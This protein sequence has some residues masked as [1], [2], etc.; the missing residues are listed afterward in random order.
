M[1]EE[2]TVY[3]EESVRNN[4]K[5]TNKLI[6]LAVV[7]LDLDLDIDLV[8]ILEQICVLYNSSLEAGVSQIVDVSRPWIIY[9]DVDSKSSV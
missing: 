3:L 2:C 1:K 4:K 6:Y 8:I 5:G 9:L 7:H